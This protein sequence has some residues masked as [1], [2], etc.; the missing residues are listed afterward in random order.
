MDL[1]ETSGNVFVYLI[2]TL[3]L[4]LSVFLASSTTEKGDASCLCDSA[5]M[6][7]KLHCDHDGAKGQTG[8][9]LPSFTLLLMWGKSNAVG[10]LSD[11]DGLLLH[12]T[13]Y[14]TIHTIWIKLVKVFMFKA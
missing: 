1:L 12:V 8:P 4:Y 2:Q 10:S 9:K 6:K 5:S 14:V 11:R 13:K 7:I 3:F